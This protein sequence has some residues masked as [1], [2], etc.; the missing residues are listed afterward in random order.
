[1]ADTNTDTNA[2]LLQNHCGQSLAGSD[3]IPPSS[4]GLDDDS[5]DEISPVRP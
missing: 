2:S 4:A 3:A 5:I 1:M